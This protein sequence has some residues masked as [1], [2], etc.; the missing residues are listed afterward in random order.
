MTGQN[1]FNI[2]A[3]TSRRSALK[4]LGAMGLAAIGLGV[5]GVGFAPRRAW[6]LTL[7]QARKQGLVG[8]RRDG[9]LG[10][11]SGGGDVAAFVN[12]INAK[13]RA[14]YEAVASQNG[15]P[16]NQVERLAAEKL[17]AEAPAGTHVMDASGRWFK[18]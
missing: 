8:E 6:A 16:L 14:A 4:G 11:V 13:R 2:A 1:G 12:E 7:D 10:Q 3:R 9:Y 15:I 17:I 18:K 5:F